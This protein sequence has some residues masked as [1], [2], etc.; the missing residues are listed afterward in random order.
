VT[1]RDVRFG[2]ALSTSAAPGADPAREGRAIEDLGFDLLSVSDHLTG[3]HPT[4]E[5]WTV[6]AWAAAATSRV[7]LA[8]TVLG[9]PYRH[10]PVV[11]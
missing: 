5:T 6:L 1:A 8:T 9:L 4:F 10:P 2:I 7:R 11:A 3:T